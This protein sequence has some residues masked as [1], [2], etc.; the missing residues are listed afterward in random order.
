MLYVDGIIPPQKYV[1]DVHGDSI[2]QIQGERILILEDEKPI[3]KA[4]QLKLEKVG[5]F[6]DLVSNGEEAFDK[7]TEFK[8][9]LIITDIMMPKMDGFR[10]MELL[11]EK[12]IKI[13]V[14]VASNLGQEEDE[15]KARDL[16]AVGY[17]VKS[18][19]PINV[20]VEHIESYFV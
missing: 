14:I 17:F 1:E 5:F 6:V 18:G 16:G 4:L 10:F 11:R 13:P 12:N 8:Y 15:K 9:D 7:I 20:L 2:L 19:V 3:G